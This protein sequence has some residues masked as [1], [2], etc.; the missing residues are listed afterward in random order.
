MLALAG[1]IYIEKASKIFQIF[2]AAMNFREVLNDKNAVA[3]YSMSVL[4]LALA[5]NDDLDLVAIKATRTKEI[6]TRCEDMQVQ[7]VA[8]CAGLL[9]LGE[10]APS[11][12]NPFNRQVGYLHRS[13]K[14]FIERTNM[15]I[16]ILGY[17]R[18]I[19]FNRMHHC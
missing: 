8:C 9:E 13:A 18:G 15:W 12:T 1:I 6:L 16:R 2:R 10:A 7:L 17:T 14:D 5:I 3:P 4:A 19:S 11:V